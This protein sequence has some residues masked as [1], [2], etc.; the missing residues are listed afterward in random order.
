MWFLLQTDIPVGNW[1][2]Y[3]LPGM[4][5]GVLL[6]GIY[7]LG[8]SIIDGANARE[9][10]SDLHFEK[11]LEDNR[12]Q[13]DKWEENARRQQTQ[14]LEALEKLTDSA[15]A[16]IRDNTGAMSSLASQIREVSTSVIRK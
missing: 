15:V 14:H 9:A 8:K 16:A 4:I 7:M 11:L 10:K 5:I 13:L 1:E 3:G 2:K 12:K 6:W